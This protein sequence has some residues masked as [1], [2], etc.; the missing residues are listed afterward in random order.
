MLLSKMSPSDGLDEE[1]RVSCLQILAA[2]VHGFQILLDHSSAIIE[3]RCSKI[4]QDCQYVS[5]EE[6]LCQPELI[7]IQA[8]ALAGPKHPRKDFVCHI[9]DF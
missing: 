1:D 3:T 9:P 4:L 6:D 5:T 7:L 8:L 2:I